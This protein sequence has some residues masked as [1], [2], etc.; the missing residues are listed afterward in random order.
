MVICIVLLIMEVIMMH[1]RDIMDTHSDA[2]YDDDDE[3][4]EEGE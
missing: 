2:R 1:I 4:E 3:E